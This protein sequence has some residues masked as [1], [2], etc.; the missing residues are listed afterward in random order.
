MNPFNVFGNVAVTTRIIKAAVIPAKCIFRK[1]FLT[2]TLM[3][4][5]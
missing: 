4:G 2:R 1:G 5:W 3:G